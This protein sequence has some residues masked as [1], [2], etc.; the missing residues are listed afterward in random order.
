MAW[1]ESHTALRNH[2]KIL[3]LSRLLGVPRAQAIG[4]LHLFW[5][6]CHDNAPDGDL[7]KVDASDIAHAADWCGDAADFVRCLVK[8]RLLDRTRERTGQ[9]LYV[10]DWPDYAGR[11]IEIRARNAERQRRYRERTRDVTGTNPLANRNV[12]TQQD[13]ERKGKERKG[14]GGDE[15]PPALTT[16]E[17]EYERM[18]A[19]PVTPAM[20]DDLAFLRETYGEED[21]VQALGIALERGKPR[22]GYVKGILRGG[23]NNDRP[24]P[25]D[26]AQN[27]SGLAKCPECGS[28]HTG[29][30]DAKRRARAG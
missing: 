10:H 9:T 19:L 29:E 11:W 26:D 30:C 8:V 16:L 20:A 23:G 12:T 13:Q 25:R 1:I 3:R 24:K 18:F 2:P 15:R 4:H 27:L 7:S 28:L 21:V 14:Q 22:L 5:W 6:W 17:Q